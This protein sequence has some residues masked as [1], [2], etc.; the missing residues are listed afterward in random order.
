MQHL[1]GDIMHFES[2]IFFYFE[3]V[4]MLGSDPNN[5]EWELLYVN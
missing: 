3:Q 1:A 4:K 5:F 2:F